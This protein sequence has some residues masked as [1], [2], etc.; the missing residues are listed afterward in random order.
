MIAITLCY[1]CQQREGVFGRRNIS[2]A[3]LKGGCFQKVLQKCCRMKWLRCKQSHSEWFT[4]KIAFLEKRLRSVHS[5]G[6][7]NQTSD[8]FNASESSLTKGSYLKW[9]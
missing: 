4:V 8:E 9:L 1:Y 2:R 5:G 7:R 6:D 3:E